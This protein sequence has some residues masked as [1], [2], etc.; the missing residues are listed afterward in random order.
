ML[1]QSKSE[2][3]QQGAKLFQQHWRHLKGNYDLNFAFEK[4]QTTGTKAYRQLVSLYCAT[5]IISQ[6]VLAFTARNMFFPMSNQRSPPKMSIPVATLTYTI[7]QD[8]TI[9]EHVN[10]SHIHLVIL[11]LYNWL[12]MHIS[13]NYI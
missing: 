5:Y 10:K 2:V 13:L 7:G 12:G 4:G 3:H 1:S 8:L 11:S 6:L 9:F